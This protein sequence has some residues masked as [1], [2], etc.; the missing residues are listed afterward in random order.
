MVGSREV[1]C[2]DAVLF[3]T[4]SRSNLPARTRPGYRTS[5]VSPRLNLKNFLRHFAHP[6]P[7]FTGVKSRNL[8][9]IFDPRR[10]CCI[11][12][13]KQNNVSEIENTL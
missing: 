5:D 10:L 3:V 6:S 11:L 12:V 13:S 7:N 9:S 1:S 2:F 8:A 4:I